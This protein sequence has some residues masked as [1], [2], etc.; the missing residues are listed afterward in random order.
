M[1]AQPARYPS[2]GRSLVNWI[3]I[4]QRTRRSILLVAATSPRQNRNAD[5]LEVMQVSRL[6][7]RA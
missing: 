3:P 1:T 7:H 5:L 6:T 4:Q 2:A